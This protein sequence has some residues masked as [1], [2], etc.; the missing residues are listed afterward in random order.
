ML[1]TCIHMMQG[2]PYVYQ[3]EELGM[4]NCPFNTLDNFRDLESINAF[5]ELTEQGKMTEEDM[6]AAIGYK[7]RDNASIFAEISL[8]SSLSLPKRETLLGWS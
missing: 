1:A 4:T 3:G 2:T 8:Y 5:H 7:G 6:M